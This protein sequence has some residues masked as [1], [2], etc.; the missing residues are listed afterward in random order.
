MIKKLDFDIW[1]ASERNELPSETCNFCGKKFNEWD[2]Q[3]NVRFDHNFG[4][5][6]PYDFYHIDLNLCCT[7]TAKVLDW[8]VPQCK[9][10]PLTED[11]ENIAFTSVTL[12]AN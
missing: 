3:E 12:V 10:D 9:H 6:S 7:C 8:L 5:G 4:Y 1:K 2:F 11:S